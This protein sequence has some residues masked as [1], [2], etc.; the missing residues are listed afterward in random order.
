MHKNQ[1]LI[2][3]S[4]P[5]LASMAQ[6]MDLDLRKESERE[7]AENTMHGLMRVQKIITMR[8][9][10]VMLE[11]G[12]EAG[13]GVDAQTSSTVVSGSNGGAGTAAKESRLARVRFEVNSSSSSS[14][15]SS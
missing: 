4:G 9:W 11:S 6:I 15:S 3:T 2:P 10:G 14:S 5:A 1:V 13:A 7:Q 12:A 8:K